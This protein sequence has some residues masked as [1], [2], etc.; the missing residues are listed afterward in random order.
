MR[1]ICLLPVTISGE[2]EI[3]RLR[4]KHHYKAQLTFG[5]NSNPLDLIEQQF[6]YIAVIDFEATCDGHQRNNYPHEII[7]FPI[8]LVNL[9][10]RKIV[11]IQ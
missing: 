11:R 4:L 7:E 10:Q 1:I 2:I 3:R 6:E 9:Q 8:V 5:S